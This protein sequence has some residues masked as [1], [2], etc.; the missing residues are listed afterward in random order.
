MGEIDTFRE[1][2]VRLNAIGWRLA[3]AVGDV[4][5]DDTEVESDP[6]GRLERLIDER[7]QLRTELAA[8]RQDAAGRRWERDHANANYHR[9]R[10]EL[11]AFRLAQYKAKD[12]NRG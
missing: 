9:I 12:E 2:S 11:A 6:E 10:E 8:A 1:H 7:D 5:P 4:G 3:E